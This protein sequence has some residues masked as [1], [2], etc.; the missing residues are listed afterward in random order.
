MAPTWPPAQRMRAAMFPVG[1]EESLVVVVSTSSKPS[2]PRRRQLSPVTGRYAA[3][4]SSISPIRGSSP[5][6]PAEHRLLSCDC[7]KIAR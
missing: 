3:S 4:P 5:L 6:D 7:H 1:L 2:L